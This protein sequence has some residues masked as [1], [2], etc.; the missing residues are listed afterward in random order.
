[1]KITPEALR[2]LSAEQAVFPDAQDALDRLAYLVGPILLPLGVDNRI[3]GQ[4]LSETIKEHFGLQLPT[5]VS[6]TLLFRLA[7]RNFVTQTHVEGS[8]IFFGV[9]GEK[10][11]NTTAVENLI[12]DFRLFVDDKALLPKMSDDEIL[13]IFMELVFEL[14]EID[15]TF[16]ARDKKPAKIDA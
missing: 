15:D 6:Q 1:M 13:D 2:M 16:D 10:V 14:D 4:I 9:G 12:K 11:G 7:K 8:S 5:E 3:T